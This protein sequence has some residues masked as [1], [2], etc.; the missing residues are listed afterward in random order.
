MPATFMA[1]C[2][3]KGPSDQEKAWRGTLRVLVVD[4]DL[5]MC[6][7]LCDELRTL[8]FDAIYALNGQEALARCRTERVSAILLDI[9]M[10]GKDGFETLMD[11]R[12]TFPE[13]KIV[14]MSGHPQFRGVDPLAWA[15][16]LGAQR[17]LPKPL[18][19][20]DIE[21]ALTDVLRR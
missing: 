12:R 7:W 3:E 10:P 1:R 13:A 11:I 2:L 5:S 20:E 15:V 14:A 8:G 21:T 19:L 9:F 4:D 6:E 16:K 17:A 18:V